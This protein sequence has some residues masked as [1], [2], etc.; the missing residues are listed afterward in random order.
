MNCFS[1]GNG[2]IPATGLKRAHQ[3]FKLCRKCGKR[4]DTML[5]CI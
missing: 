1:V 5:Y 2:D 3:K 4:K